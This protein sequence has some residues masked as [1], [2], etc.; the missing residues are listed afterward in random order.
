MLVYIAGPLTGMNGKE[1]LD[2][3]NHIAGLVRG[4]GHEVVHPLMGKNYL[5]NERVLKAGG[6]EYPPSTDRAIFGRDKWCC[7]KADLILADLS[8]ASRV[9]I[10]TTFEIAW[11]ASQN[12]TMVWTVG[13]TDGHC[14]D[15]AFVHEAT[16]IKFNTIEEAIALLSSMRTK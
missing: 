7:F 6:Y 4:V 9:S 2:H 15:H 11:G 1:S 3:F 8:R 5:M 13:M 12:D 14:M 16:D 10:G